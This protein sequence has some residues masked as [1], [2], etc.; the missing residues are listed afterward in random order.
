MTRSRN[1]CRPPL[2]GLV[3]VLGL[4]LPRSSYGA[5][6]S[7][8]SDGTMDLTF[9][10]R[11]PLTDQ[12]LATIQTE[13]ETMSRTWWDAS[14]GQLR[15]GRVTIRCGAVDEDLADFWLFSQPIRSN[16]C[17]DCLA[18]SGA[19]INQFFSDSGAVWAHEFGHLG[20][21]LHDEYTEDQT[22]CNGAGWCIEESP[23]AHDEQRQCLMQQIPGRTWT[24]LC[25]ATTH[26]DLPGDNT[27]CLVNPPSATGAPCAAGCG[28]WNT[29]TLR[30][31]DSKQEKGEGQSCWEKIAARH[32]FLRAPA[33]LPVE[34]APAG[35]VAPT[36][37]NLCTAANV[38]VL[39]LDRSGSMSWN[40]NNDWGEVCANGADD[41]NDGAVDETDDCGQARIEFVRAAGR[42]FLALS[43][44]TG[45][46][47]GIVSFESTA[48]QD[49]TIRAIDAN[50]AD[51]Q[52][53]VT[54]LL[55]GGQTSIARGLTEAKAM[56]DAEP[57]AAAGKAVLLITDGVNTDGPDPTTVVPSYQAA[58]IRIYS[59]STGDASNDATLSS[60]SSNTRGTRLDRRDGTALVTGMVELWSLWQNAGIVVPETP[61]LVDARAKEGHLDRK[62][63]EG[64]PADAT[65]AGGY[66]GAPGHQ[67]LTFVVEPGTERTRAVLAGD[68]AQMQ[69][70]GVRTE[71]RAPSGAVFDSASPGPGVTV[72]SDPYFLIVS[73]VGPEAGTWTLRIGTASGA[74]PRQ[75][76]RLIIA[77]ENPTVDLF[78]DLDKTLVLN[79]S[80]TAKLSL[81]PSYMTGLRDV[82][83]SASLERPDGTHALWPVAGEKPFQ[84]SADVGGFTYSGMYRVRA[85]MTT[86]GS[87]TN[88][89]GESRPGSSPVNTVAVPQLSRTTERF[90]F[91]RTGAW[92]CPPGTRDCDGD[93]IDE[94][95]PGLDSDGDTIPNAIDH[96]SDNDEIPDGVEG[97]DDPDGDGIPN[98]LDTDSDGDG[99]P[100]YK[101]PIARPTK[102]AACVSL[103]GPERVALWI[104]A[105]GILFGALILLL[106]Y[107]HLRSQRP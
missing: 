26:E 74:A 100:D 3:L 80:E 24:E 77:A 68:L 69:G 51:L 105:I 52:G 49:R 16:S 31:E 93:G 104:V 86:D 17:L 48:R 8:N 44:G 95:E 75:T 72:V 57:G 97:T 103:C 12:A 55:P 34:A 7:I 28:A 63:K 10:V 18:S 64:T 23:P 54:G 36:F 30:Y 65:S 60:V 56:L 42:S 11:F 84:Y 83:W 15:I 67:E 66:D 46:R 53:A 101:D 25:T 102:A 38:V 79:P 59:M 33:N 82:A 107:R 45:S 94:G 85:S 39:V 90:I 32:T 13:A 4:I 98:Y 35:F 73:L 6:G 70:F 27:A 71:L 61:Y 89:P 106:I 92:Y 37:N 91:A 50:L 62:G 47:S 76:G 9:N 21:G 96:D 5:S 20:F 87:T 2:L 1:L 58:G 99:V 81:Y 40:V 43:S 78:A 41:D 19:H 14:D 88:D 29:T 22:S